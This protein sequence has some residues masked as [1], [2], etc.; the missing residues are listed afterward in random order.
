MKSALFVL[1]LLPALGQA[2]TPTGTAARTGTAPPSA[3]PGRTVLGVKPGES[4]IKN[5]DF[6]DT[7]GYFHP[8]RRMGRFV[9][10]DQKAIWTSPFHTSRKDAKWWAI[11]G[12]LTGALIATDKYTAVEAPNTHRLVTLGDAASQLGAAYTLI[13][14]S[15]AFY[16]TGTHYH[17][18]RFR[19]AGL[20]SFEAM[21]DAT[22]VD[23]G[24]KA[25]TQRSRPFEGEGEGDFWASPGN[26]WSKSFPSG[27]AIN[28]MALAS[29]FAHEYHDKLWVKILAYSYAGG[30]EAARLAANKHFPGD[31]IAGGAMGWFI[32]DYVYAKRHN[33][34][35]EHKRSITQKVL[36]HVH[37]GMSFQ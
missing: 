10:E 7:T 8:F 22:I 18:Q 17:N 4:A 34:D 2:Q 5:K 6:Y 35:L 11:F 27:H 36:D 21:I 25:V 30:V 31:V 24:I 29:V 20:L 33:S 23:T 26:P 32:G 16:L 37:F 3:K 14:L 9:L 13:P 28:T 15:A 12:G 19:E 1:V